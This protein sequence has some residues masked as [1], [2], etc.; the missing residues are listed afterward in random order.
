[1]ILFSHK[2]PCGPN[3]HAVSETGEPLSSFDEHSLYTRPC[4]YGPKDSV[5]PQP[6]ALGSSS[7]NRL[8]VALLLPLPTSNIEPSVVGLRMECSAQL[9]LYFHVNEGATE[10]DDLSVAYEK[11]SHTT[12]SPLPMWSF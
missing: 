5:N 4:G 1:M 12:T 9:P 7:V 10:A 3:E 8:G 6:P 2:S 11:L